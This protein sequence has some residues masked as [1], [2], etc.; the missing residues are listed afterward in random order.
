MTMTAES[1]SIVVYLLALLQMCAVVKI[2]KCDF[3]IFL[4]MFSN[5]DIVVSTQAAGKKE[6]LRNKQTYNEPFE[7]SNTSVLICLCI[8]DRTEKF[9][10]FTPVS[11]Q[12]NDMQTSASW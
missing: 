10:A 9:R 3:M 7:H 12:S 4:R 5:R 6:R 1:R 8:R 2:R 11:Y